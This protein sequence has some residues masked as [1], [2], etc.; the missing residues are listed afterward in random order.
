MSRFFIVLTAVISIALGTLGEETMAHT[1]FKKSMEKSYPIMKVSCN[2]CHVKGE[3][4]T[5]RNDF[6][7]MFFKE[8]KADNVTQAWKDAKGDGRD[9]QKAY[10]KKTMTP[11]FE[12][13]LKKV[14]E[15]TVPEV[16][17]VTNPDA[18]KTWDE[19]IKAVKVD[20]IK[21]DKKKKEKLEQ[22]AAA[23]DGKA[24]STTK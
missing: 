6:G 4:K 18:G 23:K 24:D 22:E 17:G 11:L 9:A 8:L 1:I 14:M 3:K 20:G 12:K 10:E 16:E 21:I 5:V 13:A 7:E 2:A 19:M 15:A